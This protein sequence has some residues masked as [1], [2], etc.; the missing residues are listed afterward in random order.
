MNKKLNS[1]LFCTI[2]IYGY[3]TG[4][5]IGFTRNSD[6]PRGPKTPRLCKKTL[7][8][9]FRD[10]EIHSPRANQARVLQVMRSKNPAD[11]EGLPLSLVK[12]VRSKSV[13]SVETEVKDQEVS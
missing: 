5:D 13:P 4:A 1:A 7:S 6:S 11:L 9:L 10:R 12:A 8:Q 3:S 2:F